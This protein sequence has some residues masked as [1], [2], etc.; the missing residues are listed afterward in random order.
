[1]A[2]TQYPKAVTGN[3]L[4]ETC[5]FLEMGATSNICPT[6][7]REPPYSGVGWD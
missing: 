4:A 2:A 1:V 5:R 7:E 6:C 3:K